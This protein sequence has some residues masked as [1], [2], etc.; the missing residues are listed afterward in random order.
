[1]SIID[2]LSYLCM[3]WQKKVVKRKADVHEKYM[4]VLK[5]FLQRKSPPPSWVDVKLALESVL[6]GCHDFDLPH[7]V[8]EQLDHLSCE[9]DAG[10]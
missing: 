10:I 4:S 3:A 1:M 6:T 2:T 7:E 9:S 8:Q 5:Y